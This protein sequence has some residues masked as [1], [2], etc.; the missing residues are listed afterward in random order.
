MGGGKNKQLSIWEYAEN[1]TYEGCVS[2][3]DYDVDLYRSH[4]LEWE[5]QSRKLKNTVFF[6]KTYAQCLFLERSRTGKTRHAC[7]SPM[8]ANLIM[9]LRMPPVAV[10]PTGLGT[11]GWMAPHR[12]GTLCPESLYLGSLGRGS[13]ILPPSSGDR[14]GTGYLFSFCLVPNHLRKSK[15]P[16]GWEV[17]PSFSRVIT[18]NPPYWGLLYYST[19]KLISKSFLH[20]APNKKQ[21]WELPQN[22]ENPSLLS[23]PNSVANKP[24]LNQQSRMFPISTP[25]FS[26]WKELLGLHKGRKCF[27]QIAMPGQGA[28]YSHD[29]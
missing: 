23:L 5:R 18:Y 27:L 19:T 1:S 26:P 28:A 10:G 16:R 22:Q 11:C 24:N 13:K 17:V 29:I 9:S 25:T 8:D 21:M 15:G 2:S 14:E 7:F 3:S 6:L 20:G 12:L 4:M